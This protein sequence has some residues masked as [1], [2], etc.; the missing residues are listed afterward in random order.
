MDRHDAHASS[1]APHTSNRDCPPL[2]RFVSHILGEGVDA[3]VVAHMTA[4]CS[5]CQSLAAKLQPLR[6]ELGV[7]PGSPGSVAH[8]KV[9]GLADGQAAPEPD[10]EFRGLGAGK[11]AIAEPV[12][13]T[14]A[15]VRGGSSDERWR[16]FQA[17]EFEVDLCLKPG[18][19]L[20]GTLSGPPER[21]VE[22][23]GAQVVL[24][25]ERG[26]SEARI[27]ELGDF[28]FERLPDGPLHLGISGD[29]FELLIPELEF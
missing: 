1:G 21:E 3:S 13:H 5:R 23:S 29:A 24:V 4:G 19:A 8:A 11:L 15:Q 26:A 14:A 28:E 22:L 12:E 17:D 18:G 10:L 7:F 6:Q 20:L 27:D 2:D 25:G 9:L 16:F